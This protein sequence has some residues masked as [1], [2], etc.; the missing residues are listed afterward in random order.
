MSSLRASYVIC[1]PTPSWF[2]S[3]TFGDSQGPLIDQAAH[4]LIPPM[5]ATVRIAGLQRQPGV[6]GLGICWETVSGSGTTDS[7]Y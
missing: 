3:K 4:G 5:V 1:K 6:C 2:F 7:L